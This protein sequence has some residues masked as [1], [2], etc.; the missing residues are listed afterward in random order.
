MAMR[1]AQR[2]RPSQ[3]CS[4]RA[5]LRFL[6]WIGA[7]HLADSLPTGSPGTI[8]QSSVLAPAVAAGAAVAF[9]TG[10]TVSASDVVHPP[11]QPWDFKG[12]LSSY[13]AASIR[14]GHQVY[15][16]VCASCHGLARIAYR[17]LVRCH[18][19]L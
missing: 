19:M 8:T 18:H 10:Y 17:N 13:D 14:R 16:Q 1:M 5:V 6:W 4:K 11:H 12:F 2:L 3:V 9:A 7:P 15:T